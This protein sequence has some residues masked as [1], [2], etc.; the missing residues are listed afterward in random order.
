M[1]NSI[2]TTLLL[3]YW[4]LG[5]QLTNTPVNR[6]VCCSVSAKTSGQ[7]LFSGKEMQYM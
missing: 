6:A 2:L 4:K 7:W 5:K 3:N 1:V